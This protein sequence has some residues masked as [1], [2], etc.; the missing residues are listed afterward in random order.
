MFIDYVTV[1]VG[2]SAEKWKTLILVVMFHSV[3][4][5]LSEGLSDLTDS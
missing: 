2:W 5:I 1:R 4:Q 3:T